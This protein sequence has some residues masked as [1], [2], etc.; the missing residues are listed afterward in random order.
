MQVQE[1]GA[2]VFDDN[3]QRLIDVLAPPAR[4]SIATEAAA[5]TAPL[6]PNPREA[7]RFLDLLSGRDSANETFTFQ[8]IDDDKTRK[9]GGL[10]FVRCGTLGSVGRELTRLNRCGAGVY[11]TVNKI[12]PGRRIAANV[13]QVRALFVDLDGAPIAPVQA[14]TFKPHIIVES[15]PGKYHAYW[16]VEGVN[17]DE[18]RTLQQKLAALFSGDPQVCDLPRILRLP[19]FWH[20]KNR[21]QPFM[22]RIIP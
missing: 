5:P 4:P 3:F 14:W 20:Q 12:K 2:V 22:T 18:F 10:T 15:S 17:L 7:K 16:R 21:A 11:V 8:T 6:S 1:S 13:T 9:D 19:G